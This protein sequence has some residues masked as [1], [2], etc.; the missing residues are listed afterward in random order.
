[1][2]LTKN[3]LPIIAKLCMYRVIKILKENKYGV[4]LSV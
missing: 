1:M 2:F 3:Q 4:I